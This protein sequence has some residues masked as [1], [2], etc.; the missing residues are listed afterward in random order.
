MKVYKQKIDRVI[1]TYDPSD[2]N[3]QSLVEMKRSELRQ[4][5][6][7]ESTT[8]LFTY[9]GQMRVSVI[10]DKKQTP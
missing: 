7:K 8:R 6:Y 5:G 2:S 10:Y 3:E 4:T 9:R 1:I